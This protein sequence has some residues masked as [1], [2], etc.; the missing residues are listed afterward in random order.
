MLDF[1]IFCLK[2]GSKVTLQ[3]TPLENTSIKTGPA[4]KTSSK[5]K[6]ARRSKKSKRKEGQDRLERCFVVSSGTF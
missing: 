6:M 4:R 2:S 3:T 5:G 1:L